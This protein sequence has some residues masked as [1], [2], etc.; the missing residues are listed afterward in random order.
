MPCDD[1][2]G[3]DGAGGRREAQDGGDLRI[4]IADSLCCT[5]ETTRYKATIL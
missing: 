3:W 2:E 4:Q 1:P 5:A